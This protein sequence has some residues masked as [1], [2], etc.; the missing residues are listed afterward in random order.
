MAFGAF[1]IGELAVRQDLR[2]NAYGYGVRLLNHA[3]QLACNLALDAGAKFVIVDPL[4]GD[5]HL[6]TWYQR[7]GFKRSPEGFRH[8]LSIRTA[9]ELLD[10]F[11]EDYFVFG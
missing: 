3:I 9:R 1:M 6:C 8:Y 11:D 4:G 2:H 7:N 5:E 10:G